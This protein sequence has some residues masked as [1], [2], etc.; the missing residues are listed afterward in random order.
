MK[1]ILRG[2]GGGGPETN[3]ETSDHQRP[4]SFSGK[5]LYNWSQ[6]V[7]FKPYTLVTF[8]NSAKIFVSKRPSRPWSFQAKFCTSLNG[9][10]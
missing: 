7:V 1:I 3:R 2:E 6:M 10:H 9:R 8:F 5:I 4:W